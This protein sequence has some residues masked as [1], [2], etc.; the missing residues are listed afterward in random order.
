M[1]AL[2]GAL[3]AA[4]HAQIAVLPLLAMCDR[5]DIG[6]L[7]TNAHPQTGGPTI[8]IYDGHPG[9]VG[10]TRQGFPRF[11]DARARRAA[12]DR[13]VPVRERLPVV[14]A[15]AEVRQ[16]QRA[17]A[18]GRGARGA[19]PRCCSSYGLSRFAPL[20]GAFG[21]EDVHPEQRCSH[22]CPS[23]DRWSDECP[24][25]EASS[26]PSSGPSSSSAPPLPPPIAAG[27]GGVSADPGH[28]AGEHPPG[29]RRPVR[30]RRPAPPG[31]SCCVRAQLA[32]HP[33][34]R[35]H[36]PLRSRAG[37]PRSI[38]AERRSCSCGSR[39]RARARARSTAAARAPPA[40]RVDVRLPA[41][42][43][44][45]RHATRCASIARGRPGDQPV[46]R[47]AA[48]RLVVRPRPKAEGQ[49]EARA[50]PLTPTPAP[51]RRTRR[52]RPVPPSLG[53]PGSRAASSPCSG[54]YSF[55]GEGRALRRRAHRP[56][57]RGPGHHR[58]RGRPRRRA[59]CA[60]SVLFN[61]YQAAAPAATSSCT[62][63]TAATCSSRT[64]R[65]ARRR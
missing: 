36:G 28:G 13:R 41:G 1:E 65:P 40:G 23:A 52:R 29:R 22:V 51:Q 39:D 56:H 11:E 63:T 10:I 44:C 7:S 38:A 49:A 45:A 19:G 35:P 14:R 18:Q 24:V 26:S 54:T 17:A 8:F 62:P 57:A 20:R 55:G 50:G 2:L 4:E 6:G 59:A 27:A 12:A 34:A 15:V 25:P 47:R 43:A 37:R 3:H 31:R 60:G 33:Y 42:R 61:D 48:L 53:G 30:R 64:A 46:A 32:A 16:P 21:R 58:R 9:G 5:W